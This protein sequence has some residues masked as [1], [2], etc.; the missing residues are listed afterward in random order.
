LREL[1]SDVVAYQRERA[2]LRDRYLAAA[3]ALDRKLIEHGVMIPSYTL[4]RGR[5]PPATAEARFD[6]A[7]PPLQP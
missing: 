3:A 5:L 7:C 6:Q 4:E 1:R 2:R